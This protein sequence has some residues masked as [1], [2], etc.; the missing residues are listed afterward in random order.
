MNQATTSQPVPSVL[1]R[2]PPAIDAEAR[3]HKLAMATALVRT[4]TLPV[5][6]PA[7]GFRLIDVETDGRA[8]ELLFGFENPMA[9][10]RIEQRERAGGE[11]EP[12]VTTRELY[13][14]SVR[15]RPALAVIADRL[16]RAHSPARWAEAMTAA[17][18]LRALPV[19][20]SLHFFRQ[21]IEGVGAP[22]GLVRTGFRC[23]QDCGLCWQSRDWGG[24][25][26]EQTR[27]WIE[28]LRSAG[29]KDLVISGG[30]PTIDPALAEYLGHARSLGYASIALETNAIQMAKDGVAALLRDAGMTSAFVSLHSGVASVSDAITRAPGTFVRTVKGI[31]ALLAAGVDVG[32]NAVISAEGIDHLA[33]LP[34]FIRTEFGAH[35]KLRG[36]MISYPTNPY[37]EALIPTIVPHP[38][39]M[40]SALRA[41]LERAAA[42]ELA[43]TGLDGPCGPPLCAFDADPRFA[44]LTPVEPISFRT[45]IDAC[46]DCAVRSSCFGVRLADVER[47]GAQMVRPVARSNPR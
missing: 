33:G 10:V 41:A 3:A 38:D 26:S 20:V 6:L 2:D 24:F 43:I 37:E 17:K 44:R 36:L 13:P 23:N 15:M 18:Q 39:A 19:G 16:R 45:Q 47:F 12:T 29:A 7:F 8:I 40:R 32:L 30:E 28:D 22:T 5:E 21:L 34:D 27:R 14:Q 4:P 1:F 31:H 35:P 42:L 9:R 11:G 25:S 46:G